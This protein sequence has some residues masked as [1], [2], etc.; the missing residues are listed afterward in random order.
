METIKCP[1]C[2]NVMPVGTPVCYNC[3]KTLTPTAEA[4]PP[5]VP[6]MPPLPEQPKVEGMPPIPGIEGVCGI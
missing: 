6:G 5:P 1:F 3:G 4:T 2:G